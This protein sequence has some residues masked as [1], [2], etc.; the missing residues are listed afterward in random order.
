MRRLDF[1]AL[2]QQL[3]RLP[4]DTLSPARVGRMLSDVALHPHALAPFLWFRPRGYARNVVHRTP[5]FEVMVLCWEE[6]AC[7][8][9][10]DHAGQDCWLRVEHG[11]LGLDDYRLVE[12]GAGEAGYARLLQE[13]GAHVGWPGTVDRRSAEAGVHR[14]RVLEGPAVSV[15]VYSRPVER[16]R[17]FDVR[18]HRCETRAVR[19]DTEGGVPLHGRPVELVHRPWLLVGRGEASTGR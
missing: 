13:H 8:P 3:E 18:N 12:G 1:D 2:V 17:V 10:H 6:G 5:R 14:V 15:H 9:V 4:G 19:D 11:A 7:S 16:M